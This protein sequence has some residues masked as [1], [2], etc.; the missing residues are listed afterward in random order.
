MDRSVARDRN[1][2]SLSRNNYLD[3]KGR[4]RLWHAFGE[5]VLAVVMHV[6][7]YQCFVRC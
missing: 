1:I 6:D 3:S 4:V 7:G 5:G 2:L